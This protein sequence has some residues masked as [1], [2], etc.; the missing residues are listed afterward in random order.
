MRGDGM[1]DGTGARIEHNHAPTGGIVPCDD[2]RASRRVNCHQ[3]GA[4]ADGLHDRVVL[5]CMHQ[6][7]A[8]E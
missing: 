5:P 7:S 1:H 2:D 4:H 6:R 3:D 8:G